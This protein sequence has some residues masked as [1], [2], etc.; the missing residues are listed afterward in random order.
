MRQNNSNRENPKSKKSYKIHPHNNI[1]INSYKTNNNSERNQQ[2]F[3]NHI[4]QQN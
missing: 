4:R 1:Q 3:S 2:V